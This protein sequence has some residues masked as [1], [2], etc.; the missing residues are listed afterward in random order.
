MQTFSRW[1][2]KIEGGTTMEEGGTQEYKV[3]EAGN[4]DAPVPHPP[5]KKTNKQTKKQTNYMI[6][7]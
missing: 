4:S 3:R 2:K 7:S 5:K 1:K 6:C